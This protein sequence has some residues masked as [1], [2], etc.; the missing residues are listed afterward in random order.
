MDQSLLR[1][2][3]WLERRVRE[4]EASNPKLRE[5]KDEIARAGVAYSW[6]TTEEARGIALDAEE[7]AC[8]ALL[9]ETLKP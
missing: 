1:L 8:R 3:E 9:A 4:A 5:L 7:K 2:V 6:A